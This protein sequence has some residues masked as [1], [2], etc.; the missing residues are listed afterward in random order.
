MARSNVFITAGNENRETSIGGRRTANSGWTKIN[1]D[2]GTHSNCNLKVKA[3]VQGERH[4]G[5][6]VRKTC[7]CGHV[8]ENMSTK[9]DQK[10]P[11]CNRP[12]QGRDTRVSIFN[13]ELPEQQDENCI[14]RIRPH[15]AAMADLAK[16]MGAFAMFK[17]IV[18]V[19]R[20][21]KVGSTLGVERGQH[22]ID[23]VGELMEGMDAERAKLPQVFVPGPDGKEV[24]LSKLWAALQIVESIQK[25]QKPPSNN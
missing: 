13:V 5:G 23:K 21:E 12:R 22:I 19:D 18:D 25:T 8:W 7:D 1:T 20:A 10:C 16:M 2:N 6:K 14:V 11:Q 9:P 3:E 17:G 24:P 15:N 4:A